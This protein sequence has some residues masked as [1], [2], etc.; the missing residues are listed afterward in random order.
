[1]TWQR[2][3]MMIYAHLPKKAALDFHLRDV[4]AAYGAG[5]RLGLG[6]LVLKLDFSWQTDLDTTGEN[7]TF[8]S[9]G[10]DF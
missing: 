1:M 6:Y 2:P 10:S 5:V 8:F 7:F 4:S 3:G 9:I